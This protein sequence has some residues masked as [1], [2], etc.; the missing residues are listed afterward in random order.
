MEV[1]YQL[2]TVV[3][4]GAGCLIGI[5]R[6]ITG[7]LGSLLGAIFGFCAAAI[8]WPDTAAWVA[9]AWP[10][11]A[12]M[13][14]L[15]MYLPD[16][17]ALALLYGTLYL[18]LSMLSPALRVIVRPMGS[19]PLNKIAGAVWGI[20]KTA[21]LLSI[22]FNVLIGRDHASPLMTAVRHSDGNIAT[23]VMTLAP[24]LVGMP[25]CEDLA[26]Q[27]QLMEARQFD[28]NHSRRPNVE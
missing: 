23:G 25:D 5:R 2:L 7:Q 22:F 8:L 13:P 15:P 11:T 20:F 26:Y 16:A 28:C 12:G 24:A 10:S 21:M 14:P 6:G 3:A 9:Q 18:L 19:G 27:V 1:L 17:C 4:L